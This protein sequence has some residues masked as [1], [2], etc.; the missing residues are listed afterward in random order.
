[1]LGYLYGTM[2]RSPKKAMNPTTRWK[3]NKSKLFTVYRKQP[4]AR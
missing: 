4:T 1:M 3:P 2:R